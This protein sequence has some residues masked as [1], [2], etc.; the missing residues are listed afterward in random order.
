[1]ID[2]ELLAILVCPE[3]KQPLTPADAAA[4]GKINSAI[5]A[6]TL[7]NRAGAKVEETADGALIRED[8]A[9][10]Y[11]IRNDIPIMLID[12]AVSMSGLA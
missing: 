1:M 12:E 6:G 2:S 10:A 4:L 5:Q 7:N 9:F 11:L 3:T 8:G